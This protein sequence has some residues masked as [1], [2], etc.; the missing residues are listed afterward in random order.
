MPNKNAL[1]GRGKKAPY[2]TEHYRI[3]APIKP[4]VQALANQYRELVS[5]NN[6]EL[7]FVTL[8]ELVKDQV[9]ILDRPKQISTPNITAYEFSNLLYRIWFIE[10]E[11]KAGRDCFGQPILLET[12]SEKMELDQKVFTSLLVQIE[13]D[14]LELIP[15]KKK[16]YKVG[17]KKVGALTFHTPLSVRPDQISIVSK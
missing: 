5:V 17:D 16:N 8:V 12:L 9:A 10:A 6:T 4:L 2:K 14:L 15:T 7:S 1:G 13:S 11:A 3:P